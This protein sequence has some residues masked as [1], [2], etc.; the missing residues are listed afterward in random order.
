MLINNDNLEELRK[1][2]PESVDLV[3]LDPPYFTQRDFGEFN[4]KW[5]TLGDYLAYME[6]VI[7]QCERILKSNGSLY[8]QCDF[9]AV[10]DLNVV[11]R[12]TLGRDKLRNMI[13]WQRS[14]TKS[15]ATRNYGKVCDYLLYYGGT[16]CTY[17]PQYTPLT[18]EYIEKCYSNEFRSTNI[19][20]SNGVKGYHYEYKGYKPPKNGWRC[21]LSTM[22]QLDSENK[23][24]FPTSKN[25]R[26]SRK[27]YLHESKGVPVGNLW[28]DF[29]TLQHG[30]ENTGYPTQ[31]PLVLLERIIKASSNEGDLVLD[32]F[33]GS[34]T[35]AVACKRLNRKF[36]GIDKNPK[37]IEITRRRLQEILI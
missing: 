5:N 22:E 8:L 11:L 36:I 31:K 25:G 10:F 33:L 18:Q 37:S 1:I 7:K 23:L 29:Q 21:P 17:N 32:P 30:L 28:S 27:M 14:T 16:D 4:D 34:G 35:T 3:Y 20:Q 26:I 24:I 2:T 12:R 15:I 6:Q 19:A 13:T 9:N